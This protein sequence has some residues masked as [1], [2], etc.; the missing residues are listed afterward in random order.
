[1]LTQKWN[2]NN[3]SFQALDQNFGAKYDQGWFKENEFWPEDFTELENAINN[4]INMKKKGIRIDNSFE[5]LN[6]FKNY[7]KNPAKEIN[8]QCF[9]GFKNFI[10]NEFGKAMLCWNMPAVGNLLIDRPERIWNSK[11]A[12]Q[13]RKSMG[14]CKRTCRML[15]CNYA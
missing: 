3:I 4:L 14:K 8:K 15:N 9:S 11:P 10:I 1:M 7:Y 13:M 2:I 6:A 5:Q 12:N